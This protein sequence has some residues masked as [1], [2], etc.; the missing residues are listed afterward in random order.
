M[1]RFIFLLFATVLVLT[2]CSSNNISA[3]QEENEQLKKEISELQEKEALYIAEINELKSQ[4]Q[5]FTNSSTGNDGTSQTG[6]SNEGLL[7]IEVID[8][9]YTTEVSNGINTIEADPQG[10]F[11]TLNLKAENKGKKAALVSVW[12]LKLFDSED[13]E[14]KIS[15]I[16]NHGIPEK[17]RFFT[18]LNM[19]FST[20]IAP[21]FIK[22]GKIVFEVPSTSS[23][24]R[25]QVDCDELHTS[26][27]IPE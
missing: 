27:S 12:G 2:G 16:A 13:R 8:A 3:L 24:F 25:L 26:I 22:E 11:V 14:F 5:D 9:S 17:E 6:A 7:V 18:N 4:L 1:K 10:Q 15:N 23:G 21:G 19:A 20:E